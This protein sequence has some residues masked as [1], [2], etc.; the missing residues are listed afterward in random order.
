MPP[1][2]N[3]PSQSYIRDE[4][5]TQE[6][7]RNVNSETCSSSRERGLITTVY[8]LSRL[9]RNCQVIPIADEEFAPT[10]SFLPDNFWEDDFDSINLG[11]HIL[12]ALNY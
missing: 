11:Q 10:N 3:E 7:Q 2:G 5:Q 6:V 8:D 4:L 1:S 12:E 9:L